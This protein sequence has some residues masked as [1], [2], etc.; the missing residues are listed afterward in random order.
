MRVHIWLAGENL[1]GFVFTILHFLRK[2]SNK[3][4]CLTQV[5]FN[6][7]ITEESNLLG[8]FL[9]YGDNGRINTLPDFPWMSVDEDNSPIIP[10]H[11]HRAF[12][13]S[14]CCSLS[15]L[16]HQ[17]A[18][19]NASQHNHRKYFTPHNDTRYWLLLCWMASHLIPFMLS[20]ALL[21]LCSLHT[22]HGVSGWGQANYTFFRGCLH[23]RFHW[24]FE[25]YN[26]GPWVWLIPHKL[27]F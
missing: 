20:V 3:L 10:T 25:F 2:W 14:Y 15:V 7:C 18:Q 5:S 27:L 24:R 11:C 21:L 6:I 22:E 19:P 9:S 16:R 12:L 4:D 23:R 1:S 8:W 26:I 13:V 17:D